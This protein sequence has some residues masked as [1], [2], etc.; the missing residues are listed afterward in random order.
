[1]NME[2]YEKLELFEVPSELYDLASQVLNHTDPNTIRVLA[3]AMLAQTYVNHP[4][5]MQ[6]QLDTLKQAE[7]EGNVH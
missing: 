3:T 5:F 7:G 6:E 2:E 4:N 1:M